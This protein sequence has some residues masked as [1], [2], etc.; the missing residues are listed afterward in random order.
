MTVIRSQRPLAPAAKPVT[1]APVAI[2]SAPARAETAGT[3]LA[4]LTLSS[5]AT[6]ALG[7]LSAVR[8]ALP[9]VWTPY[10]PDS[11]FPKYKTSEGDINQELLQVRL[12]QFAR[13][14]ER[15]SRNSDD[16]TIQQ[17]HAKADQLQDASLWNLFA[18]SQKNREIYGGLK[19]FRVNAPDPLGADKRLVASL[20]G[21]AD[22]LAKLSTLAGALTVADVEK[23]VVAEKARIDAQNP[24][25]RFFTGG[26][27]KQKDLDAALSLLK[28]LDVAK[29]SAD[30]GA[31]RT[32]AQTQRLQVAAAKTITDLDKA[33][34]ALEG[35]TQ[36]AD[37]LNG[38]LDDQVRGLELLKKLG[39]A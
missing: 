13:D 8:R 11:L 24:I 7:Q 35:V 25:V 2:A 3:P 22:R 38:R 9:D 39:A 14:V 33:T 34:D 27:G 12:K 30:V 21:N 17:I 36:R 32:D 6:R 20:N 10:S 28:S 26:R 37:E 16:P 15:A 18:P 23:R 31:L 1:K 19:S 4:P 5:E 29:A